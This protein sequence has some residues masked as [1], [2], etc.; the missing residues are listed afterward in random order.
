MHHYCHFC[1]ILMLELNAGL[2]VNLAD[3]RG[4]G[5]D[6]RVLK[7]DIL[8]YVNGKQTPSM[9]DRVEV[10]DSGLSSQTSVQVG[11]YPTVP[12]DRVEPMKG[13]TRAMVKSMTQANVRIKYTINT[14]L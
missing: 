12:G 13:Y 7:E 9:A 4:T 10:K 11:S 6:G 14:Q 5:R 8:N 1:Y 3:V 2:Q